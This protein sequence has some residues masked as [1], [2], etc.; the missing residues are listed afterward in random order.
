MEAAGTLVSEI[1]ADLDWEVTRWWTPVLDS[2]V[3]DRVLQWHRGACAR[4][5]RPRVASRFTWLWASIGKEFRI[6]VPAR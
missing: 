6:E 3:A 5:E 4:H 2:R 1:T